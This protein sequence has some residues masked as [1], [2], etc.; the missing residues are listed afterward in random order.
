MTA[1][2]RIATPAVALLVAAL[3]TGGLLAGC[4]K[5]SGLE[6]PPGEEANYTYPR[7]YPAPLPGTQPRGPRQ[8]QEET[9]PSKLSP[10]P[11]SGG[12]TTRTY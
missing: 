10:F 8:P 3:G 12:P 6:P 11:G 1:A 9:E 7:A 5:K 4:G 2:R